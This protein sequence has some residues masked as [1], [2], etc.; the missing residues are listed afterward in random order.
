MDNELENEITLLANIYYG[1]GEKVEFGCQEAEIEEMKSFNK[2]LKPYKPYCVVRQWCIWDMKAP[3]IDDGSHPPIALVKADDIIEDE[4]KRFPVGGWVRSTE[5]IEIYKK[6]IF[7]TRNSSYIL[8]GEGTR[9]DVDV[10]KAARI[11]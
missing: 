3:S 5:I 11:F 1:E 10:E 2:S 6:C 8:V 7:R 9:L 4:T